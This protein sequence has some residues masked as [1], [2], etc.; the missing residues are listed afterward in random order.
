MQLSN[1]NVCIFVEEIWLFRHA[2]PATAEE[3]LPF[4]MRGVKK[5]LFVGL[6]RNP[7]KTDEFLTKAT[8]T[9][10]PLDKRTRQYNHRST[11]NYS[12][13][14]AL[15]T[16]E[17]HE[18]LRVIMR[19]KLRKVLP[20]SQLQADSI[21]DIFREEVQRSLRTPELPQLQAMSTDAAT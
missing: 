2:D 17:L 11:V 5:R 8:K 4:L 16:D 10:T 9:E 6:V 21:A 18:T 1:E 7:P 12:E 15:S 14:H 19:E 3:K 13:A 20:S